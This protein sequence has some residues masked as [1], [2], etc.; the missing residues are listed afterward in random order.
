MDYR[1][2]LQY[3][4]GRLSEERMNMVL[5]LFDSLKDGQ[6][7]VQPYELQTQFDASHTPAVIMG[8]RTLDQAMQEFQDATDF[9]GDDLRPVRQGARLHDHDLRGLR[10]RG[11]KLRVWRF[12][13][14][15]LS[16]RVS[17]DPWQ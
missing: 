4:K 5:F 3:V 2:C 16:D 13:E 14:L 17:L 15:H 12:R 11:A 1:Q 7:I 8:K 10:H 6:G 9:F